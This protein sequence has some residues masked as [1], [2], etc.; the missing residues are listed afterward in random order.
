LESKK[1]RQ[2]GSF[3]VNI[4]K[5]IITAKEKIKAI[6][7]KI[8]KRSFGGVERSF[9]VVDGQVKKTPIANPRNPLGSRS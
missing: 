1:F 5:I 7:R 3:V 9:S 2:V 8:E 4:V 6:L